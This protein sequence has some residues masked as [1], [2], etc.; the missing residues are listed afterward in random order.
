MSSSYKRS[1]LLLTLPKLMAVTQSLLTSP[2]IKLYFPTPT[3]FL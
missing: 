1:G 3:V 2:N